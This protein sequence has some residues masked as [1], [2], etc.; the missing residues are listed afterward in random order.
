MK[1]YIG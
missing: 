1:Y